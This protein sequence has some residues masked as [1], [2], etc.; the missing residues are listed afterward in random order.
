[1][2]WI[3]P[4]WVPTAE[5]GQRVPKWRILGSNGMEHLSEMESSVLEGDKQ[6]AVQ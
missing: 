6:K 2:G 1:M 5:T 3:Q 4:F